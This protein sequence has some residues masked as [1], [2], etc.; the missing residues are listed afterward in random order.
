MNFYKRFIGDYR[1]DTGHLT[2]TEHGAYA[3][4]LDALY[5]TRK[6][7]PAHESRL[8]RL[9]GAI[10]PDEQAAV[11]MVLAEFWA[12]SDGGWTNPRAMKE[13]AKAD[14][15]ATTNRRIAHEREQK[16]STNRSTNRDT[17]R[18]TNDEPNHSHSHTPEPDL[19]PEKVN[20]VCPEPKQ[21]R[22]GPAPVFLT[23]PLA[24]NG[25]ET[26]IT[27]AML[28]EW[29]EAYPG[30]DVPQA[31]RNMRQW[32][33]QNPTRRKTKRGI[34]RFIVTWLAKEQ[35]RGGSGKA[36]AQ[37]ESYLDTLKGMAREQNA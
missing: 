13:I 25:D 4:M 36:T 16:K 33:I 31:L 19:Q 1:R 8:F 12:R 18:S 30:V 21:V 37:Q 17:N 15:Q 9:L 22:S 3:L 2:M 32:L 28:A 14:E 27:E 11:R 20:G 10:D 5:A 24:K 35:D 26:E 29:T 34:G 6:P 7:L 23:L